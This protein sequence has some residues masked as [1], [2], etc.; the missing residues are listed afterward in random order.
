MTYCRLD[1]G[2]FANTYALSHTHTHTCRFHRE[3]VCNITALVLLCHAREIVWEV[4]L[5]WWMFSTLRA[6]RGERSEDSSA[7][8][9]GTPKF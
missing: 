8:M 9:E 1:S 3:V 5:R 4:L 6:E 7:G 2:L